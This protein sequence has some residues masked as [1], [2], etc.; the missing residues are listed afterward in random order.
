VSWM[1][2]WGDARTRDNEVYGQHSRSVRHARCR[3]HKPS[4][5]QSAMPAERM[6]RGSAAGCQLSEGPRRRSPLGGAEQAM[7][8]SAAREERRGPAR[9]GKLEVRVKWMQAL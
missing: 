4:R 6:A 5:F 2:P 1:G 7:I 3:P 9:H 8:A